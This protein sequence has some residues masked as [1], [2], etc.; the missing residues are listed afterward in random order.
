MRASR[1]LPL[2]PWIWTATA[3]LCC[4]GGA[5]GVT[6]RSL[7][8]EEVLTNLK[9]DGDSDGAV[10][11]DELFVWRSG[12]DCLAHALEDVLDIDSSADVSEA[13][14]AVDYATFSSTV[15]S[16]LP[17]ALKA[18]PAPVRRC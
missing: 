15:Y 1:R 16:R 6:S 11:D 13:E 8:K 17:A 5:A 12:I 3:C 10:S 14:G 2:R 18:S 7:T 4:V 9:F